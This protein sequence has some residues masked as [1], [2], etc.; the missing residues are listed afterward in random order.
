[1][2]L[3][4]TNDGL[5]NRT[6]DKPVSTT[7]TND[8]SSGRPADKPVSRAEQTPSAT[9]TTESAS[10][11]KG[12]AAASA[13]PAKELHA[14][15]APQATMPNASSPPQSSSPQQAL[16][17]P[18]HKVD[19]S[20]HDADAS[21]A[22]GTPEAAE[23]PFGAHPAATPETQ[24]ASK[25]QQQ[26]ESLNDPSR[27]EAHASPAIG[28]PAAAAKPPEEHLPDALKHQ[29]VSE[30][31]QVT[32]SHTNTEKTDGQADLIQF[33]DEE[34]IRPDNIPIEQVRFNATQGMQECSYLLPDA[35]TY[36]LPLLL[37][38]LADGFSANCGTC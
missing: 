32:A 35:S 14:S 37:T 15:T 16:P 29:D 17:R 19:T 7:A 11:T 23:K 4:A 20:R 27:Q 3:A 38:A 26:T 9:A 33:P 24:D 12:P 36:W 31:Q 21:P 6:A 25:E 28:T 5:N 10:G 13:S 34:D 18:M 2:G 1:M 30:K 8:S 22:I